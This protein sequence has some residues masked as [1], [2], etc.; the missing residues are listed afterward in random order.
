[1]QIPSFIKTSVSFVWRKKIY[2][3]ILIGVL[4]AGGYFGYQ[5]YFASAA[6][7]VKYVTS[8]AEIGSLVSS[9]GGT[10][11]VLPS[12][13]V[14]LKPNASGKIT[15]LYVKNGQTVKEGALILT[16][17]SRDAVIGVNQARNSLSSA[18][19]ALKDL[20]AP[21][22]ALTLAQAENSLQKAKDDLVKL[23]FT[24]ET[25][26]SD[27]IATK[28]KAEDALT[29][30]Y[31]DAYNTVA[32]TFLDLPDIMNTLNAVLNGNEISRSES[33]ACSSCTND[34]AIINSIDNTRY[35]EE[36][37]KITNLI[38]EAKNSYISA[39]SSF[40]ANYDSYKNAGRY[41]DKTALENLLA[42][43]NET[44]KKISDSLKDTS[45][46][47]DYWV[48]FRR[49]HELEIYEKIST[50]QSDLNSATSKTNSHISGIL[51]VQSTIKNSKDSITGADRNTLQAL[52]NT[53]LAITQAE[54]SIKELEM[55]L[56]DLKKGA[57]STDISS[58]KIT[59]AQRQNDLYS[60]QQ[61]LADYSL[62][63]PF[64]GA[65]VNLTVNRGDTVGSGAIGTLMTT[66]KIAQISLNE[67]DVAKIKVGQLAMLS[68]DALEDLNI[69]GTVAEIDALGTVSQGVVSYTVKI[70]FDVQDERI[71]P[72]MTVTANI[73]LESKNDVLVVSSSAVKTKNG[74]TVVQI[75]NN[76]LPEDRIVVT[77][78][79]NDTQTEIVSGLNEGDEIITQT[80][81]A[82]AATSSTTSAGSSQNRGGGNPMGG[83]MRMID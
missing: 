5:K 52:Q 54:R 30:A 32:D 70:A 12:S 10:G 19:L 73:I 81:S 72:N 71:K 27:R 44:L 28:Q 67:I 50:Y 22:N 61:K 47:L 42:Q 79:T 7:T 49:T 69:S 55:K 8:A 2:F 21:D 48:T 53:P 3:I 9:I 78:L 37:N 16:I 63:A 57:T 23:R 62:R 17:D 77:G 15:R 33:A 34:N 43:T 56:A 29:K 75:L 35:F 82:S 13:Q 31:E 14:E 68:F 74:N 4:G 6:N 26:A 66:Q 24:Q 11:Q 41:S 46:A 64:A 45:N 38:N 40:D 51:S 83:V 58:Q 76:G 36:R 65:I 80:I 25:E 60:A 59:L 1:M 20:L 18:Q 39:D